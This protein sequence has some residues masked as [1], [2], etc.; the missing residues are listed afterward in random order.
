MA[1]LHRGGAH[2]AARRF[3]EA[4]EMARLVLRFQPQQ[5]DALHLLGL[6]VLA[7][8]KA[9]EAERLM[10]QA[11]KKSGPHAVL[12]VN[13]G[14]AARAQKKT[15]KALKYYDQA[16][17]IN[18]RH[19][20]IYIERGILLTTSLRYAEAAA[21][22]D[23]AI[24][25]N[26]ANV[27][28]YSG[29]A[30]V[31]SE[32]GQFRKS[33]TYCQAGL[34]QSAEPVVEM[35]AMI[36]VSSERLSELDAAIEAANNVLALEPDHVACLRVLTKAQRRQNKGN[37][38]V[39]AAL[40][41]RLEA[42]DIAAA[43]SDDASVVYSELAHI[44]DELGEF[45][46]AYGYFQKL[47]ESRSKVITEIQ[48]NETG[49]RHYVETL[50]ASMTPGLL[51]KVKANSAVLAKENAGPTPVFIIGFPRSGTTLLDQIMDAH[52]DVQVIEERPMIN[53]LRRVIEALPGGFD[54]ALQNLRAPQIKR[55]RDLYRRELEKNGAD[56]SKRVIID[57][58]P[59]N[60]VHVAIIAAVF[61][62]AKI[63]L[64][65]RHPADS[66]LSCFMQDFVL[67]SAMM[68]FTSMASTVRLYD[69]VMGLWQRYEA[70]LDLKVQRVRYENL[71]ADLRAE[72]G[73]VLEFLGLD[74]DEAVSDPAAHALARGTIRTP[75]YSQVTQ[76]IYSSATD[77]WR[78][79]APF[80]AD[81]LPVLEKHIAYFGYA[82]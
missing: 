33:I 25:L 65:L 48:L 36:A 76:P 74:W 34:A 80:M 69:L 3:K 11:L 46:K 70:H 10:L 27:A 66:C 75:S 53:A 73:P 24:A 12:L 39:L 22:F 40:K 14:N 55:L 45:E 32:L 4:E 15:E 57:K 47:N 52:K 77:R 43:S 23:Q 42:V 17:A 29:A 44:C 61:P 1:A 79:Y 31:A 50:S 37:K 64:S 51:Q 81:D 67:N 35:M 41:L 58:M 60:I 5:P 68:N 20:D 82:D 13:L 16:E 56:F 26:P 54:K 72:V 30:H 59:L 7:D 71:V 62:E 63:I 9:A 28:A 8:G 19:E 6:V 38:E 21:T 49:Y 2:F 18:P 78:R